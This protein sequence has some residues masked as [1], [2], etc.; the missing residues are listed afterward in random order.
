MKN[1]RLLL[2][3]STSLMLAFS[4]LSSAWA[5]P[6]TRAKIVYTSTRDGNGEIYMINADGSGEVRLTN[7]PGDDFDP[8]WSPTGEN[9][10][11]VSERDHLGLYDIYLMDADGGNIRRAFDELDYRTAPTWSPDGERI[12]YHTYSP[13]PDWAVYFNTLGGGEAERLSEAGIPGGGFP[14]WSPDGTEI[15]FTDRIPVGAPI[16]VEPRFKVVSMEMR[17]WILNLQTGEKEIL[18]PRIKEGDTHYPIWS[19]D[20]TKL[21]F[22]WWKRKDR[23]AGIYIVNRDRKGL[24]EIVKDAGGIVAWSPSGKE[25]LF[26]KSVG[27]QRQLFKIDLHSRVKAPLALLGPSIRRG[28][29]TGWD[30]FDPK[31]LP[32]SPKPHLLTTVWAKVKTTD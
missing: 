26:K 28:Q 30:W 11:F 25:L 15:A 7:H 2:F 24:E 23:K 27:G 14:A 10:A 22:Y 20:G 13:V 17:I 9:I 29:N 19:P 6:P 21:A 8:T 18:L 31:G 16:P 3:L 4:N 12:A 5:E 32:V 1:I